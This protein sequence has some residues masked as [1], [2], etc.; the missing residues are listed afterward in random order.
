[1]KIWWNEVE[2]DPQ[3][4]AKQTRKFAAVKRMI[5]PS[6]PRLSA[7]LPAI[8]DFK[9][10]KQKGECWEAAKKAEKDKLVEER[11]QV[12]VPSPF[13]SFWILTNDP[14]NKY[15]LRKPCLPNETS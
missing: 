8:R 5:K 6:D 4:K 1:M 14:D 9:L 13:A 11:K 15:H 3:G 10:T 12:Y 7:Y 2:A